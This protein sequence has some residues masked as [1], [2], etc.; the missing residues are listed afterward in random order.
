MEEYTAAIEGK[1]QRFFGWLS[2]K[3]RRRYAAIEAAKLGHGGIWYV[4]NLGVRPENHPARPP[5][6]GGAHG[7]SGGTHPQK[8]GGRPPRTVAQP[9]LEVNLRHLWE[10]S[11]AGDPMRA[12]VL[13]TNLSLSCHAVC[14]RWGPPPVGGRSDGCCANARE[15]AHGTEERTIRLKARR[16]PCMS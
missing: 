2:E 16:F 4:A 3:D 11:T 13:W 6:T 1:M 10:G 8:R 15:A 5:R 7:C 9:T 12:G 14:W